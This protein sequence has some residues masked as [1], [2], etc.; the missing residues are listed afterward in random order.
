[1]ADM[2]L[3]NQAF[4]SLQSASQ[5]AKTLIGFRDTTMIDS[6]VI[7]LR[8]H[9]I[10]AQGSTMQAQTQ[11]SAL[12]QEVRD[13][14]QQIMDMEKWNEEKQRYQLVEPW[15]GCYVYA[16]KE[17]GKGADPAH[18]ICEHCY[19]DGR[20][21]ILQNNQKRDGRIHHIIKCSHCQFDAERESDGPKY[22]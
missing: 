2:T 15:P 19:Q 8:D 14:K 6:K 16:L 7:E 18:W 1:M 22:A 10:E 12:I 17:S 5:L 9:L 21:S 4:T 13:L 20:K 3:F 11:Q